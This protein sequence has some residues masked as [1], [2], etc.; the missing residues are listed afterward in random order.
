MILLRRCACGEPEVEPVYQR[1]SG[2]NPFCERLLAMPGPAGAARSL[3]M[4]AAL[5]LVLPGGGEI[6]PLSRRRDGYV[7]KVPRYVEKLHIVRR[8]SRPCD[9]IGPYVDDRRMLSVLVGEIHL[10]EAWRMTRMT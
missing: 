3:T 10:I 6:F 1:L 5:R 7:F 9:V 2:R 4:D 8:V